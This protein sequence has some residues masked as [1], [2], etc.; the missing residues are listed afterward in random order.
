MWLDDNEDMQNSFYVLINNMWENKHLCW[1][2]AVIDDRLH[3]HSCKLN[4]KP[5][6]NQSHQQ[7]F[8][9]PSALAST[10]SRLGMLKL[11]D[12]KMTEK[13]SDGLEYNK[14]DAVTAD[15]TWDLTRDRVMYWYQK[16]M[17]SPTAYSHHIS[18]KSLYS[19]L[20]HF[21]ADGH[22]T[23]KRPEDCILHY[24]DKQKF[25]YFWLRLTAVFA[26]M[27]L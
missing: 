19:T 18:R 2:S 22:I 25:V 8:L 27:Q 26:Y 23:F 24:L 21:T 11:Q 13:N 14:Q 7:H 5:T 1:N 12:R 15:V 16:T 20:H 3:I 10:L 17:A 6:S 4:S 9:H